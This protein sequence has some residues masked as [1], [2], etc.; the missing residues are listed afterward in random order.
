MSVLKMGF[1]VQTRKAFLQTRER[2]TSKPRYP[3]N[4]LS[5]DFVS[6]FVL[7]SDAHEGHSEAKL[8]KNVFLSADRTV[9][10]KSKRR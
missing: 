5:D 10:I 7:F 9:W 4:R 8:S 2:A 1:V 6:I 3:L